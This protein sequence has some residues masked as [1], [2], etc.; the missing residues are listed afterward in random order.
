MRFR[1][2]SNQGQQFSINNMGWTPVNKMSLARDFKSRE[3]IVTWHDDVTG[4][5]EQRFSFE[6]KKEALEFAAVEFNQQAM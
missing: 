1:D 3:I 5:H 4:E 6:Q 2:L